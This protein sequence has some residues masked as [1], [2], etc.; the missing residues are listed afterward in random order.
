VRSIFEKYEYV[1]HS[2]YMNDPFYS[3][4]KDDIVKNYEKTIGD[5]KMEIQRVKII[6]NTIQKKISGNI[7]LMWIFK[8][9]KHDLSL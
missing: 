4:K 2:I 7:F 6:I 8:E 1:G 3:I 9:M 5:Y